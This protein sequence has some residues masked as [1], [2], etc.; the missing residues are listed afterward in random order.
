MGLIEKYL[1]TGASIVDVAAGQGNF[2]LA[3]AEAGYRVVW[4]DLRADLEGYVRM[5][6][7][8]GVVDYAGGNAFDV[9]DGGDFDAVMAN[10]I[11]EHVAHPDD[12][13]RQLARLCR[14]G[15]LIFL[16][17]PNGGYWHTGLPSFEEVDD[18]NLLES[19]QFAPGAEGHLF[20]LTNS[21]LVA[22]A[23]EAGLEVVEL[24]NFTSPLLVGD[25]GI[26]RLLRFVPA[27]AVTA[28][29]SLLEQLPDRVGRSVLMHT[30]AVFRS[31]RS[32]SMDRSAQ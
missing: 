14:P 22:L 10:E 15:G 7:E 16:S 9:L 4:N 27:H 26:N 23:T 18:P 8:G 20:L 31:T 29:N 24:V 32:Q 12:L 30:C 25:F 5:K 3:M 28:A 6:Y 2:T 13:L 11:I 1:P 21:E 19:E 17:T